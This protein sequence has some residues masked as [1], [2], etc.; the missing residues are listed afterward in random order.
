MT[1]SKYLR[2]TPAIAVATAAAVFV[3]TALGARPQRTLSF[4]AH[5]QGLEFVTAS[6]STAVYPGQLQIG[7]R[8]FA[9]DAL[10]QGNDS[11]GY[12]NELCTVTFDGHEI[13]Q[14][15]VVLPGQGQI[16]VNWLWTDWP[17]GFTGVIDGGTGTFAHAHGE[18]TATPLA[19]GAVEFTAT[20]N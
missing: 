12:D 17:S 11:V 9:R 10:T 3:S 13:C 6:G 14:T 5:N 18:F 8:I 7:D 1:S 19:G 16:Q 4:V 2:I 20:L 15:T